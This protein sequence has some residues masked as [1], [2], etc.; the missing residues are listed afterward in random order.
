MSASDSAA[1]VCPHG[2]TW[3]Q[4]CSECTTAFTGAAPQLGACE[5]DEGAR[6]AVRKAAEEIGG[7]L[8][9]EVAHINY[10]DEPREYFANKLCRCAHEYV[11]HQ[12]GKAGCNVCECSVFEPLHPRRRVASDEPREFSV[13]MFPGCERED[14]S[15]IHSSDEPREKLWPKSM[16]WT[17]ES[18]DETRFI[19]DAMGEVLAAV[20]AEVARLEA[21][22]APKPWGGEY[23]WGISIA[24]W[25]IA[26]ALA[27]QQALRCR[28]PATLRCVDCKK[29]PFRERDGVGS[30]EQFVCHSCMYLRE[31]RVEALARL[32]E[33]VANYIPSDQIIREAMRLTREGK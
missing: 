5:S 25:G 13:C 32:R 21:G 8:G 29:A 18:P 10:G 14:C 1:K 20:L 12:Y 23:A 16:G 15:G 30:A 24:A 22:G 28:P 6:E 33:Y 4:G 7:R 2:R 9:R 26:G 11:S 17:L 3:A 19:A 31:M 27:I